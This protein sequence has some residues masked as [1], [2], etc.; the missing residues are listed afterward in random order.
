MYFY[1]SS[2]QEALVALFARTMEA[3][4]EKSRAA[5]DDPAAPAEAIATACGAP[6]TA[7]TSTA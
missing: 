4:R 6:A 1:F 3:L 7:G 2:R 5:A